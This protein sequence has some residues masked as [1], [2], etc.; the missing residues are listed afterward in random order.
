MCQ[1][2]L[3]ALRAQLKCCGKRKESNFYR[4]VCFWVCFCAAVAG[5]SLAP[6]PRQTNSMISTAVQPASGP[7]HAQEQQAQSPKPH[8]SGSGK[9]AWGAD[10]LLCTIQHEKQLFTQF[11]VHARA[12]SAC[13]CL[14]APLPHGMLAG[15]GRTNSVVSQTAGGGA[16]HRPVSHHAMGAPSVG[17]PASVYGQLTMPKARSSQTCDITDVVNGRVALFAC[18]HPMRLCLHACM[19]RRGEQVAHGVLC[20]FNTTMCC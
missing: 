17:T 19:H 5:P 7:R 2:T 9:H 10:E 12:M 11:D 1:I 14:P 3:H 15:A 4:P 16:R 6:A 8:R 20:M 13:T 18:A